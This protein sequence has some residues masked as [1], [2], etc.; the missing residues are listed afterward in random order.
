MNTGSTSTTS[1]TD[2]VG[3]SDGGD[4]HHRFYAPVLEAE[5]SLYVLAPDGEQEHHRL[6][7]QVRSPGMNAGL[8]IRM[9][10]GVLAKRKGK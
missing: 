6:R 5:N 1:G 7:M 2:G 10:W 3:T 8:A 9:L 4:A